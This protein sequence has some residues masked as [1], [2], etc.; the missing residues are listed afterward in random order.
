MCAYV[1]GELGREAFSTQEDSKISN[2]PV[3]NLMGYFSD[4]VV[5]ASVLWFESREKGAIG[6]SLLHRSSL[7]MDLEVSSFLHIIEY[8][9]RLH[10]FVLFSFDIEH[11]LN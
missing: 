4:F 6:L 3:W 2:F 10:G 8:S 11:L 7:F 5:R 1:R 9:D